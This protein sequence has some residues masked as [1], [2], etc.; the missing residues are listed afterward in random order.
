[1]ATEVLA[2]RYG[3]LATKKNAL[4]YRYG[5]Y[6]DPDAAQQMDYFFRIVRRAATQSSSTRVLPATSGSG[7]AEPP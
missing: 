1:M 7:A 3:T 6:G 5:A 2:V 4:F